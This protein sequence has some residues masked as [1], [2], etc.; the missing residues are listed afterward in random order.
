VT[1]TFFVD[2]NVVVYTATVGRYHESCSTLLDAI[3]DGK[4]EGRMSTAVLEEI[5][6]LELS[7]KAGLLA[8][9]AASAYAAFTPLLPVTDETVELALC[10]DARPLGANDRIHLATCRQ[11]SIDTIVT[12][13]VDFNGVP[14][15]HR[16]DP[17][18]R[19]ALSEL[20]GS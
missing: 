18:D 7:G 13:D 14:G 4:A 10:L 17:L 2:A 8:G 15:I 16:V 9:L 20:L 12:A 3:A 11:H 19:R 1:A 6:H 5:W